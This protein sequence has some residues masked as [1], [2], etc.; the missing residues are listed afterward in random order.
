M[1]LARVVPARGVT[2]G[3]R[4]FA[5]GTI[6]SINPWVA[7]YSTEIW[8]ADAAEFRPERWLADAET[9]AAR[10]RFHMP[11]SGESWGS[12]DAHPW[13]CRALAT[14]VPLAFLLF[15]PGCRGVPKKR[16]WNRLVLLTYMCF[17][18]RIFADVTV[19]FS[20]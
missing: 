13:C 1:T 6:V 3:D 16:C 18:H 15:P 5:P 14:I 11:L 20:S 4:T 12:G 2:I 17:E 9:V 19:S 10:E 8:G 7:H